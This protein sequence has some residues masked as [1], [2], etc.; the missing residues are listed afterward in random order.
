MYS[1][2]PLLLILVFWWLIQS[3]LDN[4]CL[5][6]IHIQIYTI[7]DFRNTINWFG[8]RSRV[9]WFVIFFRLIH[10]CMF[11]WYV[12]LWSELNSVQFLLL[13]LLLFSILFYCCFIYVKWGCCF[14]W[15]EHSTVRKWVI[16]IIRDQT[17]LLFWYKG[18]N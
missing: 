16:V 11:D 5:V 10:T 1:F 8:I 4:R 3:K 14:Y 13:F 18:P 15:T 6:F 2:S 7:I 17:M 9:K 12:L